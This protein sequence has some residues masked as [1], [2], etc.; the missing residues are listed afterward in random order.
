[1]R[2]R[3][4]PLRS[5]IGSAARLAAER[6]MKEVCPALNLLDPCHRE[7]EIIGLVEGA[8]ALYEADWND[9]RKSILDWNWPFAVLKEI[10]DFPGNG[11]WSVLF[12]TALTLILDLYPRGCSPYLPHALTNRR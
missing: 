7:R 11:P 6:F 10:G 3:K 8:F 4:P 5:A 2:R 12:R 1:M 9:P